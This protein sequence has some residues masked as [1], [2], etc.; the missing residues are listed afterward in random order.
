MQWFRLYTDIVDNHKVRM[1]AFEDRWHFVAIMACKSAGLL[2]G[3]EQ[4]IER[5]L[6]VKLGL[7]LRELEE[8]K[9][10]LMDVN[11]IDF[12][13][14]PIGWDDRQ[15]VSDSSKER[16]QKYREKQ[17]LSKKKVEVKRYGNVTVTVQ[18][19]DTDTEK[20]KKRAK[21]K[22]FVPPTPDQVKAYCRE[23][24]NRV[25]AERFVDFYASKGWMVGKTKMRDWKA[26]VRTWE[27]SEAPAEPKR[28]QHRELT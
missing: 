26:S 16:V 12:N 14:H 10:R 17:R 1:I 3:E 5:A 7:Q 28:P 13:W 9:R 6:S 27:R 2:K 20:E 21:P 8:L 4:F 19:T 23:R 24:N 18:D 11:L 15:Y 22:R 25:D